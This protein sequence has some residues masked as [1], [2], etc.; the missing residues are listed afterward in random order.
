MALNGKE[1]LMNADGTPFADGL[2]FR[3][4]SRYTGTERRN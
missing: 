1:V 4:N 3:T 2:I